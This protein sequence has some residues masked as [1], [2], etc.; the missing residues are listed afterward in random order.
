MTSFRLFL[1]KDGDFHQRVKRWAV[2]LRAISS[3]LNGLAGP[4]PGGTAVA[5]EDAHVVSAHH[6]GGRMR[7]SALEY[8]RSRSSEHWLMFV[9]GLMIGLFLG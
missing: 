2:A 6:E 7:I 1:P 3:H 8:L 5:K 4:P 9:I